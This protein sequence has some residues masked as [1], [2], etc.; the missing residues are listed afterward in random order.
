MAPWLSALCRPCRGALLWFQHTHSCSQ[1]SV[2]PV[3]E[4]LMSYSVPPGRQ[5]R[6]W[7]TYIHICKQNMPIHKNKKKLNAFT[8]DFVVQQCHLLHTIEIQKIVRVSYILFWDRVFS[9]SLGYPGTPRAQL[10]LPPQPWDQRCVLLS[11]CCFVCFNGLLFFFFLLFWDE[12]SCSPG[13]LQTHYVAK[14]VPEILTLLPLDPKCW[15]CR[16]VTTAWLYN[17]N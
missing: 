1:T 7:R 4:D 6:T 2:T 11:R 13:W 9:C 8:K 15:D 14:D 5:A 12:A 17:A 16:W 3:P 10:P